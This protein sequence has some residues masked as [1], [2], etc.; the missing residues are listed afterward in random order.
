MY[1]VDIEKKQLVRLS[2]A[3][4]SELGVLERFDIEEWV[5]KSPGILGEEL[6]VVSKE[7]RLPSG[8]RLD[9]LALD[10]KANLV[11][12]E[13][14]RDESGSNVEWQAVKHASYCSNFLPDDIYA[15]YAEYLQLDTDDAQ[16]RIEG[17]IDEELGSLNQKQRIILV[18]R[19]FHP[20]A[21]SAVL[22]LR[23]YEIDVKCIRLRPFVDAD[24]DLFITPDV[25]IP[26][27]EAKDYIERKEI[28]QKEA[29]RPPRSSFSLEKGSFDL[30][31]LEQE[32]IK[33][34]ARQTDLT[35]RFVKFLEIL[36]SADRVFGR[37]EVKQGL[38][39]KGVGSNI[40]QTGTYLSNIS[41]FLTKKSNPHLRQVIEFDTGGGLGET[42]DNYRIVSEYRELLRRLVDEWNQGVE[43]T[44]VQS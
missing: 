24:G 23:D 20:D 43:E 42:K 14:K 18:A 12:V 9:L 37:E 2:P 11:V 44:E 17:F 34:L 15:Y 28:K 25:I 6:L 38:F 40:G 30:P 32:M 16:L 5:E 8:I 29:K 36:L 19:E 10:K 22:W 13:L 3:S 1:K 33:T 26:L 31:K 4:F 39:G 41:Q 21:V 7:L 35:P 27:P